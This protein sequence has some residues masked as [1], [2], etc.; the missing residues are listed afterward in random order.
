MYKY[1]L[2]LIA[3]AVVGFLLWQYQTP[4]VQTPT[5]TDLNQ[6]KVAPGTIKVSGYSVKQYTCPACLAGAQCKAC[7]GDNIVISQ[8]NEPLTDYT[9]LTD[10][11]LIIFTDHPDKYSIGQK[12][13]FELVLE[14]YDSQG[15]PIYHLK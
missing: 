6:N 13:T 14:S 4:L 11:D 3:I 1:L 15:Q 9:K 12:Y 10:D 7:M 8:T 5:I 2:G